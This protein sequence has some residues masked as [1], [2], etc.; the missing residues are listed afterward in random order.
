M[1]PGTP[2]AGGVLA[3]SPHGAA[4][5]VSAPRPAPP[6]PGAPLRAPVA[7]APPPAAP[8]PRAAPPVA[9]RWMIP[10]AKCW[11]PMST[12]RIVRSIPGVAFTALTSSSVM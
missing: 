6:P 10:T 2:P 12:T 5:A 8:V 4:A 3:C 11:L 9:P 7:A 1:P